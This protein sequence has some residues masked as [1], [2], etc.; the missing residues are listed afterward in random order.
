MQQRLNYP[1]KDIIKVKKLNQNQYLMVNNCK[2]QTSFTKLKSGCIVERKNVSYT[3]LLEQEE[4]ASC[5][6]E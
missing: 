6:C 1:S 2:G 4:L 3:A 5:E